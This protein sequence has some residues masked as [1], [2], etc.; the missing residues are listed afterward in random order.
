[1]ILLETTESEPALNNARLHFESDANFLSSP[2]R[3]QSSYFR[4]TRSTLPK[5][6]YRKSPLIISLSISSVL[7]LAA[8]V[9]IDAFGVKHLAS[10]MCPASYITNI[11]GR[12]L[13]HMGISSSC[14]RRGLPTFQPSALSRHRLEH[15]MVPL[16]RRSRTACGISKSFDISTY[17]NSLTKSTSNA[18]ADGIANIHSLSSKGANILKTNHSE[19]HTHT[20]SLSA[21]LSHLSHSDEKS[22]LENISNHFSPTSYYQ[23]RLV[24]TSTVIGTEDKSLEKEDE[25]P[26]TT[27][28]ASDQY[29]TV[30]SIDIPEGRCVGVKLSNPNQAP[31]VPTS[32]VPEQIESNS[33]HWLRQILHEDEVGYGIDLPSDPARMSFFMGRIAMRTA[34]AQLDGEEECVMDTESGI[35]ID[36]VEYEDDIG[37]FTK[38]PFVSTMDPSILKDEHGRPQVPHGYIGS[39]SHKKDHGVALV[40]T[41]PADVNWQSKSGESVIPTPK[42][43]IGV[44]IE[45]SFSRRRN[46]AKKILTPNELND[47]GG[48]SGVTQD[49]EVL[50][51]FRCVQKS[52]K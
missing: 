1:M 15:E 47:L 2:C 23:Q 32:I 37:G 18:V 7:L 34:L 45:Q 14:S 10:D 9:P 13:G 41:I 48:L 21:E 25:I 16:S 31:S 44:D 22:T 29:E 49:E 17:L 46:I 50:L 11:Y 12:R 52:K 24:H 51:R 28:C 4:A 40:S 35:R 43:G 33:Q 20:K 26:L 3:S 39:I 36:S 5:G 42:L 8:L 27:V 19:K 6:L 38:L 30:F